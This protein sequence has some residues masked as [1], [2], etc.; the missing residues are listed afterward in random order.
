ML[1]ISNSWNVRVNVGPILPKVQVPPSHWLNIINTAK[2][3][4][5]SL[6]VTILDILKVSVLGWVREFC[7][8]LKVKG[9]S[10][11]GLNDPF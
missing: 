3:I 2:N 1:H 8:S 9:T 5:D 6:G 4:G 11:N 10:K 7:S